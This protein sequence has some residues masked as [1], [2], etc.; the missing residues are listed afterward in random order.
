MILSVKKGVLIASC[1]LVLLPGCGRQRQ[2]NVAPGEERVFKKTL[3]AS[4]GPETGRRV[5]ED[6]VVSE[7]E[8]RRRAKVRDFEKLFQDAKSSD[9]RLELLDKIVQQR[10]DAPE[11]VPHVA[12]SLTDPDSD[13][14]IY[15]LKA[16]VIISPKDALADVKRLLTDTD[17]KVRQAAVEAIG[18]LPEPF[19]FD[20]LFERLGSERE[21][22][23]QQAI[24]LVLAKRGTEAD[25][26]RVLAVVKD[27]DLK[28]VGPVLELARK[29]LSAARPHA[30]S[31]AY[32]I[33]RNDADLRMQ[34]AKFLGELGVRTPAVINGLVRSLDDSELSVRQAA[35]T[36]L[37]FY[38]N[39]EFGYKPDVE[40]KARREAIVKWKAWAR[41]ATGAGN[42]AEE[43]TES[44]AASR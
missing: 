39:Q 1:L 2:P 7:S 36:A 26:P 30:D 33:D 14:R 35:F 31:I 43:R 41:Q 44:G 37:K 25:V 32:F 16:R 40:P 10:L 38:S 12:R 9:D 28:A 23:V 42:A 8:A 21:S 13:Q 27:L 17:P 34:V 4:T 5:R 3:V 18:T 20:V 22:F 29:S 6:E 24:T 19:P 11:L 15:A